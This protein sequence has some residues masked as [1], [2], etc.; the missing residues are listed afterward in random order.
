MEGSEVLEPFLHFSTPDKQA[1]TPIELQS[2]FTN[3]REVFKAKIN[4]EKPNSI[5]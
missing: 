4:Q 3:A 1:L 5:F 2:T